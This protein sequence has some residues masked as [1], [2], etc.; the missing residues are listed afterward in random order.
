MY[1]MTKLSSMLLT[2]HTVRSVVDKEALHSK[3]FVNGLRAD[4]HV[5]Y[6]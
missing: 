1:P 5:T 3:E 2:G 6:C 4:E